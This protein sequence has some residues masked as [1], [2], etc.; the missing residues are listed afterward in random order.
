MGTHNMLKVEM[1]P[2]PNSFLKNDKLL[3]FKAYIEY[4]LKKINVRNI[5]QKQFSYVNCF[6]CNSLINNKYNICQKYDCANDLLIHISEKLTDEKESEF[7]VPNRI[8]PFKSNKDVNK[9]SDS[10]SH[11]IRTQ[12]IKYNT[13]CAC[14]SRKIPYGFII[15]RSTKC[16][17]KFL[18]ESCKKYKE[19][20]VQYN[21]NYEEKL[22]ERQREY[23]NDYYND[24]YDGYCGYDDRYDD[25]YDDDRYDSYSE[26][27]RGCPH[28][29]DGCGG[30]YYRG[31][32]GCGT[33]SCGCIDVCRGRCGRD[34]M[35]GW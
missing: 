9:I 33:L 4:G 6:C 3:N 21:K 29:E 23:E 1:K 12:K 19:F 18:L 27:E 16:I 30:G 10:I 15:C 26:D 28:C 22:K 20:R 7:I 32:D 8:N 35:F 17:S 31:C 24:C 25:R 13:N 5:H 14:C 11:M 34:D 2:I